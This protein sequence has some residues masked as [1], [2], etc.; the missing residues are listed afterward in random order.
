VGLTIIGWFV[1]WVL[2]A[3]AFVMA[4]LAAARACSGEAYR[5]PWIPRFL[6]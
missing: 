1:A 2:V 3:A 5:Y 4:V 6:D